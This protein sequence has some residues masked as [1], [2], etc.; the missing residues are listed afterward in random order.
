MSKTVNWKQLSMDEIDQISGAENFGSGG[1]TG[2]I[3]WHAGPGGSSVLLAWQRWRQRWILDD[4]FAEWSYMDATLIR[5]AP[6]GS[7]L[8]DQPPI[9]RNAAWYFRVRVAL[10]FA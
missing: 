10:S 7:L 6:L 2:E 3:N 8:R 4:V 5:E 9:R 1:H